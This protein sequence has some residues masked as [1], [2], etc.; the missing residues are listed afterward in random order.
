MDEP[1]QVIAFALIGIAAIVLLRSFL[2]ARRRK[3]DVPTD[4]A[5]DKRRKRPD[6]RRH[7]QGHNTQPPPEIATNPRSI[8]FDGSNVM[9]WDG[10]TPN[11]TTLMRVLA[12]LRKHGNDPILCFD[13]NVG[14]KLFGAHL[15]SADL[16]RLFGVVPAQVLVTP[17][18]TDADAM[19]L[20]A[21]VTH[22]IPVVSN[23]RYLDYPELVGQV[24][25][26]TGTIS[27]G[28]VTLKLRKPAPPYGGQNAHPRSD[29]L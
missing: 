14:Y 24:D 18:G 23:D 13:A 17:S 10:N 21:A 15:N 4:T 3:R 7:R 27:D 8:L 26:M 20:Q 19:I 1:S 5:R 25:R 9:H 2:P 12:A 22:G 6:M 28:V 29:E 11:S 16:G